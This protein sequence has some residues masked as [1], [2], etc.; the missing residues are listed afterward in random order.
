MMRLICTPPSWL[1]Y[2]EVEHGH[3]IRLIGKVRLAGLLRATLEHHH[4]FLLYNTHDSYRLD[5][6]MRTLD[7][8]HFAQGC[9][10]C[11]TLHGFIQLCELFLL[12]FSDDF[13]HDAVQITATAGCLPS[14][15]PSNE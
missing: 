1:L 8:G 6:K 10:V 13:L 14:L 12:P 11:S 5:A 15:H 3:L 7:I 2:L 9:E 4:N